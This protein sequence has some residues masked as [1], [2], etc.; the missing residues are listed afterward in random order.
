MTGHKNAV[1]AARCYLEAIGADID[2][3]SFD[4]M[5]AQRG[6]APPEALAEGFIVATMDDLSKLCGIGQ[7]AVVVKSGVCY[8]EA[9]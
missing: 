4:A 8:A 2:A 7:F 5:E 3:P 1:R 9:A 6:N